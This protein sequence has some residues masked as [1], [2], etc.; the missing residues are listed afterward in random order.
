LSCVLAMVS[1]PGS[2][3]W[4]DSS[5][6]TADQTRNHIRRRGGAREVVCTRIRRLPMLIM[7][8]PWE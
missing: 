4:Y 1:L 5:G 2:V 6:W 8:N 3:D 7:C